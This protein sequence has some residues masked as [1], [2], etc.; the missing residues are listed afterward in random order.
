M[1]T[2]NILIYIYTTVI[3]FFTLFAPSME[4]WSAIGLAISIVAV[5]AYIV[6][7]NKG[8]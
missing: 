1:K 6:F 8:H 4:E 5:Y 3:F 2:K 7:V